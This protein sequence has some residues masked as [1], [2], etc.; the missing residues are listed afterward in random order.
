M[1][2]KL[3]PNINLV[4]VHPQ[5]CNKEHPVATALVGDGSTMAGCISFYFFIFSF[6]V[7]VQYGGRHYRQYLPSITQAGFKVKGTNSNTYPAL[8]LRCNI[9]VHLS[10]AKGTVSS[11]SPA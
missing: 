10:R 1:A 11:A 6:W 5:L 9:I 7:F 2:T 8:G 4:E 3:K